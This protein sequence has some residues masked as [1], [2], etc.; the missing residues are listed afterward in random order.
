MKDKL[1]PAEMM[2]GSFGLPFIGQTIGILAKQELFYWQ[3]YQQY[4]NIFKISLPEAIGFGKCACLIGPE[5]NQLVLK[6]AAD[7]LSSRLGNRSLEPI[8]S[9]DLVLLQD[10][11]EHRASRKLI[12]PIFHHQAIASYFD[13]IQ[14]VATATVTDWGKQGTINLEAEMR[15]LTLSIAVR[16]FL[17]SNKTEEIDRVSQ[18]YVTLFNSLNGMVKWDN[19][20]TF[21]GRG[22]AARRKIA[23][24][25]RQIIKDRIELDDIEK[26]KDVIGFLMSIVD[27]DGNKFTETQIINQA[28][29]F[30]FA[31]HETTSSLMNWLMF[32]LGNRPEWR[33]QL[34]TEL[35]QVTG[36]EALKLQHLR[37][38]PQMSN[39]LKEG[40]RL[41][42]P[43]HAL[44]RAVVEDIE[45]AG[46]TI[47]AGWYAII[48]PSMTH[49][50]PEIYKDPES[51]DPDRFAPPRE[52]DKKYPYSLIGFGGGAHSCIGVEFANMEMKIILS[53]LL[54]KYDWTVTPTLA[55][56]APVR[57]PFSMQKKLTATFVS[58]DLL[59]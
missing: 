28:I 12:L 1:K 50:M 16:T 48:F 18:W 23:E 21:Y 14:A 44:S 13:T 29:G 6:D 49:R 10:G 22:Q 51:F 17:G 52:E 35:Q 38:L 15:K 45:Y 42:P 36:N 4:G 33:Q 40:E 9:K 37:Q 34:R 57:K 7:K 54:Q 53:T 58:I 2:P 41:Y 47:P 27:E 46:Y 31:A 3:Q 26:S 25:I 59:Y 5:A 56:I 30:L 32:E 55:E 20:L 24:Y 43:V 11:V 8:V 39:V 19:P